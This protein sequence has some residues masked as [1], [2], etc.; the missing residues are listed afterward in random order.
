MS[1]NPFRTRFVQ[2][3][4]TPWETDLQERGIG[5]HI[6]TSAFPCATFVRLNH[7]PK[8]KKLT[9]GSDALRPY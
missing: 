2:P 4:H 9:T 3:E 8:T 6:E 1:V 7:G 5:E